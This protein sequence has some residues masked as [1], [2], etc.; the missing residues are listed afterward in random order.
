MITQ[1]K[2]MYMVYPNQVHVASAD[3]MEPVGAHASADPT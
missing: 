1:T 3:S 2:K